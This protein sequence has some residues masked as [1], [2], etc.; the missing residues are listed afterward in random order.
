MALAS[1][2]TLGVYEITAALGAGGLGEVYRARDTK[3]GR[4]VAIKVLPE[5]FQ[6]DTDRLA[7]F[8]REARMLASLNHPNIAALHGME[9]SEERLFLVMELVEG[10]T[11]ADRLLRGP[12]PVTESLAVARQIAEAL[13][14]AHEKGVIHRDLKPANVKITPDDQ[15][16]VLDFGLAKAMESEHA[17]ASIANSPTLSRMATEAGVILGTA[18]YMSPEQGKGVPADPRSDIFSFGAVLFEMLTGRRPFQGETAADVLASVLVR[19]PDLAALPAAL[20]PRITDLVRRCLEKP[21]KR[22]WQAIGDIRAEIEAILA[23]PAT[24]STAPPSPPPVPLWR[25]AIPLAVVAI[26]SAALAT[27]VTWSRTSSRSRPAV[28]RFSVGL[29]ENQQILATGR[30]VLAFSPDGTQLAYAANGRLFLRT[31]SALEV[32]PIQG[33]ETTDGI[34]SVAFS[35]DGHSL[36]FWAADRTMKRVPVGGGAA[37]TIGTVENPLGISW[38]VLHALDADASRS[39][40]S[41]V[42]RRQVDGTCDAGLLARR[43]LGGLCGR[44]QRGGRDSGLRAI[45]S[46]N[47]GALSAVRESRG[48]SPSPTVDAGWKATSLRPPGRRPGGCHG[49]GAADAR[50]RQGGNGPADVPD[51]R[52]YHAPDV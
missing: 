43:A 33:T 6:F 36:V 35:P 49:R 47:R 50:F 25:R 14:A 9:Q 12:M 46:A 18:A 22:R 52:A 23:A 4:S 39:Q 26:V 45:V 38:S 30:Q 40:V 21:P 17:A 29:P 13:E 10:E 20:N 32:H 42:Q 11:L 27:L 8:A 7:R 44:R 19:D 41:R 24:I 37:I 16:K 28:T 1:G 51:G 34:T 15:V 31:M 3:L 5:A 2:T 48:L